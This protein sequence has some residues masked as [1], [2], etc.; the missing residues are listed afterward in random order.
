MKNWALLGSSFR[1]KMLWLGLTSIKSWGR[2][3]SQSVIFI[4]ALPL[5]SLSPSATHG[6]WRRLSWQW[7]G[8]HA[9]SGWLLSLLCLTMLWL[10]WQPQ[11]WAPVPSLTCFFFFF[12]SLPLLVFAFKPTEDR[13][14]VCDFFMQEMSHSLL[15]SPGKFSSTAF[16]NL[17]EMKTILALEISWFS[18]EHWKNDSHSYLK[19]SQVCTL[20]KMCAHRLHTFLPEYT[21]TQT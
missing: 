16:D 4:K 3:P 14:W 11:P 18:V 12:L 13:G 8:L 17:T 10:Y 1:S 7:F 6:K 19:T 5:R 2:L 9:I 15:S 21:H 20:R